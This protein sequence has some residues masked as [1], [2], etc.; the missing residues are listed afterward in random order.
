MCVEGA[1]SVHEKAISRIESDDLRVFVIWTS[2]Y[3]GDNRT[4]AFVATRI[5]PD[6]RATHFW[7]ATGVLPKLYGKVLD[8][9]EGK[10]FAWDTYMVFAA[11]AAWDTAAPEPAEWMHQLGRDLGRNHP[12]WLNP[13]RFRE[14]VGSLLNK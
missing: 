8:L 3:P 10:Q 14:S 6:P 9:P 7:D 4:K 11:D 2:R 12:R 1:S 5:V 13:Q